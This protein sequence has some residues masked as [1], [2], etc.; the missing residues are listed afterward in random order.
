M[1]Y[2]VPILCKELCLIN[3]SL[4]KGNSSAYQ[5]QQ[6]VKTTT[7]SFAKEISHFS[8]E[9]HNA[10]C[11]SILPCERRRERWR[12]W[13]EMDW[14]TTCWLLYGGEQNM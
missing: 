12:E 5:P 14:R 1:Q 10:Q 7:W 11:I 2:K 6:P 9:L 4:S 13:W 3:Y 8:H